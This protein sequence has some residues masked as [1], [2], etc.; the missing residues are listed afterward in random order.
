M[1]RRLVTALAVVVIALT[2][3]P[4]VAQAEP[5]EPTCRGTGCDGLS[6]TSVDCYRDAVTLE[7]TRTYDGVFNFVIRYSRTCQAAWARL[8]G[9]HKNIT[10]EINSYWSNW[11]WRR[12]YSTWATTD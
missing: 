10:L 8:E 12:T 6:P 9:G 4:G 2:A 3:A 7:G 1:F 11:T 5:R